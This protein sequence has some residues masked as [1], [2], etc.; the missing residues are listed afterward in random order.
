MA[1]VSLTKKPAAGMKAAVKA[2]PKA[3]PVD[4]SLQDNGD[5]TVTIMG[6]DAAGNPVDISG[7]ATLAVVSADP[8]IVTVDPPVGLTYAMHAI[9]KLSTPGTPVLVTSTATWTDGSR[10]P[11]TID[12]PVDVVAGPAG[13]LVIQ[14]GPPTLH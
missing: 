1:K 3:A 11:F 2:G 7:V 6:V 14:H 8:T 5:D 4:F 13:G 12:D 9:G 10:G